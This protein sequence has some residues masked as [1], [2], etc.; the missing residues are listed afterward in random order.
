MRKGRHST[1]CPCKEHIITQTKYYKPI[2]K[3]IGDGSELNQKKIIKQCD[4]CF[5]R[6]LGYCAKGILSTAIQL[7]KN[8]YKRLSGSKKLLLTLADKSKSVPIKRAALLHK[9]GSGIFIPILASAIS[10]LISSLIK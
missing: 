9:S 2:L 8:E 1:V 5:I 3:K 10:A 6:Y 4:P 7:P